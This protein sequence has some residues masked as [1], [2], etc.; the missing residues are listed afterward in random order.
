MLRRLPEPSPPVPA[1]QD[2][3]AGFLYK[4]VNLLSD[5]A[6]SMLLGNIPL[7]HLSDMVEPGPS[8]I[9]VD[10]RPNVK[11][12]ESLEKFHAFE[13]N[14]KEARK[15]FDESGFAFI[16]PIQCYVANT[17]EGGLAQQKEED[18]QASAWKKFRRENDLGHKV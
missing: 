13:K 17:I 5:K 16:L 6:K 1:Y 8:Y 2:G 11:Q 14:I 3:I 9:P 4:E 12:W 18:R 10:G 7:I 15:I